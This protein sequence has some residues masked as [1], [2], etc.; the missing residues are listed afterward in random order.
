MVWLDLL[1]SA[2]DAPWSP[3]KWLPVLI[4]LGTGNEPS[5]DELMDAIMEQ[6]GKVPVDY[7]SL[8]EP[9]YT[10]GKENVNEYVDTGT[11]GRDVIDGYLYNSRNGNGERMVRGK[12][13]DRSKGS[14]K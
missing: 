9:A 12:G 1:L 3:P 10:H 5:E 13:A 11:G 2:P 8:A 4:G 7:M 6:K 14:G